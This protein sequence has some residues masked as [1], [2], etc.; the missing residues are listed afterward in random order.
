MWVGGSVWMIGSVWMGG[1]VGAMWVGGAVLVD[2][3]VWVGRGSEGGEGGWKSRSFQLV[4]FLFYIL[5]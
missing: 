5:W 4:H 1:A 2:G 3:A